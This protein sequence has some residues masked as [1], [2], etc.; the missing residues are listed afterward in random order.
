MELA[1]DETAALANL[2]IYYE[3]EGRPEEAARLYERILSLDPGDAV[4]AARLQALRSPAAPEEASP[5]P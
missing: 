1:P 5:S 4:A 2:A 3:K